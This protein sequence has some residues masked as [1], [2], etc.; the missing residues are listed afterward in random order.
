M[1]TSRI[2]VHTVAGAYTAHFYTTWNT[3]MLHTVCDEKGNP[4]RF[5]DWRDA[6]IA[7]F[8]ARDAAEEGRY[9]H[10]RG[11]DQITVAPKFWEPRSRAGKR[12]W[13]D[14]RIKAQMKEVSA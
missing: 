2:E 6:K 12:R 3:T 5:T 7:A 11:V 8:E 1:N 13:A 10:W 4:V 14:E 9:K